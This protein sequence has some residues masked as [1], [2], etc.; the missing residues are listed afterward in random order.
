[1]L[2]ESATLEDW[3]FEVSCLTPL[4]LSCLHHLCIILRLQL[5]KLLERGGQVALTA[6]ESVL[7]VGVVVFLAR[8]HLKG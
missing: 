5:R 7:V 3:P 2:V 6:L 1:M 4:S 8:E